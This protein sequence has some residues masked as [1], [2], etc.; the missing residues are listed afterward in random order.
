MTARLRRLLAGADAVRGLDGTNPVRGRGAAATARRVGMPLPP[1]RS[2][3][4]DLPAD[5]AEVVDAALDPDP[6]Y[7]PAPAELPE[8]LREAADDLSDEGGLV[9]PETL[10]RFGLTAVRARTRLMT[11]L[12]R[13]GNAAAPRP[14]EPGPEPPRGAGRGWRAGRPP[15]LLVVA[16]FE[17]LAPAP[18]FSPLAAAGRGGAGRWRAAARGLAG[19]RGRRSACGWPR[20][21]RARI[22]P[23]CCGAAPCSPRPLLLPRAGP[24]W[25][26]PGAGATAGPGRPGAAVRGRWPRLQPRRGGARG[27]RPPASSGSRWPRS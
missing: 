3:R 17:S 19:R 6:L 24:L 20:R 26:L 18:S 4:R 10:E 1:L 21:R 2:S 14:A 23:R 8:V 11:L 7:R 25:S 12:H 16:G 27:W 15:A 5:L 22:G 9:E 13:G